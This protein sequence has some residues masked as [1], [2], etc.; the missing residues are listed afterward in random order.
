M[1]TEAPLSPPA[2]DDAAASGLSPT[3][4]AALLRDF[5]DVLIPGDSLWPS[6]GNV[7][8]QALLARRLVESFGNG[9]L[10]RVA[11]AVLAAGGPLSDRS[12]EERVAI[13]RQLEAQEPDLFG[14]LRDAT[15]IA[16]YESPLVA[17]AINASGHR[18]E[19]RPHLKGYPQR[20][21]DLDRDFPRHGR[22]RYLATEA[23]RR[24]DTSGLDLETE[25]TG[26]WGLER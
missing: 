15:Y 9:A 5:V 14:W 1:T 7:G 8:A 24:V 21:F 3:A 23:V 2:E 10:D 12:E 18:Y 11:D 25:R 13:V 16:Y 17:A 26:A 20:P 6:A 19:L 22:G 4:A